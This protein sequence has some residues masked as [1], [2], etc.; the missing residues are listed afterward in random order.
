[1]LEEEGKTK[2]VKMQTRKS[3]EKTWQ[4]DK[5]E[6]NET[7]MP[8]EIIDILANKYIYFMRVLILSKFIDVWQDN[9]VEFVI[10]QAQCLFFSPYHCHTQHIQFRLEFDDSLSR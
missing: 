9:R 8:S 10:C 7:R 6:T 3:G 2:T 5:N 1:M 4:S